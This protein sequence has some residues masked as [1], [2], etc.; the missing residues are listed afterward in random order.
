MKS[1]DILG[2][3]MP[4]LEVNGLYILPPPLF[5]LKEHLPQLLAF[6]RDLSGSA[7]NQAAENAAEH[8][9]ALW[10]YNLHRVEISLKRLRERQTDGFLL[11]VLRYLLFIR[12]TLTQLPYCAV[13][14][15]RDKDE[16]GG[17]RYP[18]YTL[19]EKAVADYAG[20][21]LPKVYRLNYVDYLILRREAFIHGMSQ[22]KKGRELLEEAYCGEQTEPDRN[23]LRATFGGEQHGE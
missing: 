19:T 15:V 2:Q 5:A 12:E 4:V 21:P 1:K 22:T 18:R 6:V 10:S 16:D 14:E 20:I 3:D 9:K 13:P 11:D 7:W 23:Q 8:A 17:Y